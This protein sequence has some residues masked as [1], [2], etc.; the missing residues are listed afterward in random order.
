MGR[1]N[2]ALAAPGNLSPRGIFVTGTGTGV[3]KTIVTASLVK[4][5]RLRGVDAVALKPFATGINEESSWRDDDAQLLA[6]ASEIEDL[7]EVS[8]C[9]LREPLAPAT[10][11]KLEGMA[12]PVEALVQHVRRLGEMHE[13]LIVEGVGGAAVPLTDSLLLSDFA[14]MVGLPVLVVARTDLGT[15]NHTLLTLE[16]LKSRGCKVIGVIFVRH[17]Q[18]EPTLAEQTG[19]ELACMTADVESFGV[20]PFLPELTSAATTVIAVA[21]LPYACE[22]VKRLTDRLTSNFV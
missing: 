6:A 13:S 3:G 8:P 5:L 14:V 12:I 19:P 17:S 4:A 20:V 9:R 1:S 16:H 2:R 18:A 10:A 7:S 15:V 11:A 22:A 21:H